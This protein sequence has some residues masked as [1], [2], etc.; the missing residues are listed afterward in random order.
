MT[1]KDKRWL[2]NIWQDF[3]ARNSL[4]PD[5]CS[6][7]WSNWEWLQFPV[8]LK[9]GVAISFVWTA[10]C[11]NWWYVSCVEKHLLLVCESFSLPSLAVAIVETCL[12]ITIL[13]WWS[14]H[15]PTDNISDKISVVMSSYQHIL[16]MYHK[17]QIKFCYFQDCGLDYNCHLTYPDWFK[18]VFLFFVF[19]LCTKP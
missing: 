8:L 11:D 12:F 19:F 16:V 14:F 15:Q 7:P 9:V 4:F 18:Q 6:L 3:C 10:K 13:R 17:K 1:H 5:T 2:W